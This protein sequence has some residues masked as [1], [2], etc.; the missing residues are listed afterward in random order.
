M[1]WIGTLA[2]VAVPPFAGYYSKDLIL[3]SAFGA[4]TGVGNYAFLMGISAA[5]LTAFYSARL[6]FLTFHGDSR[7]PRDVYNEV[8]ESPLSMTIPLA[9]LA[10]GAISAGMLGFDLFV[11]TDKNTFWGAS[12]AIVGVD[13]IEAAHHV[14]KLVIWLPL[15]VTIL[16]FSI[17]YYMYIMRPGLPNAIC[18][19]YPRLYKFIL[20][21]WYFDELYQLVFVRTAFNLGHFL[22]KRSDENVINRFGPD[23]VSYVVKNT[24]QRLS[25]LQTG[26]LY[27][28]AFIMIIALALI[29]SWFMVKV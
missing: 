5:L 4:H 9:F 21:K 7:A 8:H 25:F 18:L 16:G 23:G 6:L 13:P 2:L 29:V 10:L 26:Y 15:I 11:G 24:A 22:W 3:E 28:Y 12:I 27:H 19:H 1:M 17:A 20:N 14:P